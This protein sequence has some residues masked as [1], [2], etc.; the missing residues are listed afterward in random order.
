M[1][2]N[3]IV[4]QAYY[5]DNARPDR[6]G[7]AV[8][9]IFAKCSILSDRRNVKTMDSL[10]LQEFFV[11]GKDQKE[12]HVLLHIT[13]PSNPAEEKKGYF[14]ALAELQ[15]ASLEDVERLQQLIDDLESG[16]YATDDTK[17]HD[18]F[19]I[20]LEYINRRGG[21]ILK[22]GLDLHLY[23]GVIKGHDIS[24]AHHGDMHSLLFYRQGQDTKPMNIMDGAEQPESGQLFSSI[25]QGSLNT[26]DFL[27]VGTPHI[28]DYFSYDRLQKVITSRSLKQSSAHME[29]VLKDVH[30]DT[31][32][33]GIVFRML[34]KQ[35]KPIKR[36]SK[37]DGSA[38]SL[39]KLLDSRQAT[40]ETLSPPVL[41]QFIR[42]MKDRKNN[43]PKER[44]K[45]KTKQKGNVE[46]NYRYREQKT[47]PD[48]SLSNVIL[49]GL[50][51][52]IVAGGTGLYKLLRYTAL[53]VGK[54]LVA[55]FI[56]ITNKNNSRKDVINS[57]R[58][59]IYSKQK[60]FDDMPTV[61]KIL[62]VATI[63]FALIFIGSLSVVKIKEGY[64]AK[65]VAYTNLVQA[66][67]DKKDAAEAKL[68]Y[69]DQDS[70]FT[71]L[72]EAEVLLDTFP[73]NKKTRRE[74]KLELTT[75]VESLMMML[76]KLE[77][78]EPELLID[79]RASYDKA[80]TTDIVRIE[81]TLVAFGPDS[82]ETYRWNLDSQ[83]LN[84]AKHL[85]TISLVSGST[86]KEQ[87][88]IY[89]MDGKDGVAMYHKGSESIQSKDIAF[90]PSSVD[91]GDAVIYNVRLYTV[92]KENNQ[93]YKHNRTQTGFDKGQAWLDDDYDLSDATGIAVDG[94]IFVIKASG[95]IYK[96]EK[97]EQVSFNIAGIDPVLDNPT[98]LQT[99]N[100]MTYLYVLEPTNNRIVV[101][102][103]EGKL[104]KQISS[105]S[106]KEISSMIVDEENNLIFI[107][108]DN[109]IYKIPIF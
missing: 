45:E 14:V 83:Q 94:D 51:R 20:T 101:I 40:A 107:L 100:D 25:V 90:E 102:D 43:Q 79:L 89:F 62:F 13:E 4:V 47:K 19:E 36:E 81:N 56:L 9:K 11:E 97:G 26:G 92:D 58:K 74:K 54:L 66:I 64:Q 12:S 57:G 22:K 95:E 24:F 35:K 5:V 98:D 77:M 73:E 85:D 21:K 86:P 96:F 34:A 93:V 31:S 109:K 37:K 76:R 53:I 15:G 63:F 16:F 49:I 28:V 59:Y 18:S 42:K 103:K 84:S 32:Y 10:E 41:K 8:Y 60:A 48:Q 106:W 3:Q 67:E 91:I 65:K 55:I 2:L 29:K 46:T 50:G 104:V 52:A 38:E 80:D 61:S 7:R 108:D 105:N 39:D 88:A 87:D 23:V 1:F 82:L 30:S 33:G 69:D 70:A 17:E 71:L 72:K 78:I 75:E 99:Y 68:I 44:K 6:N 27:F